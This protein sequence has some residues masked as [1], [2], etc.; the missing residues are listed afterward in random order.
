M[1]SRYKCRPHCELANVC[2]V[3][4]A[5]YCPGQCA[6]ISAAHNPEGCIEASAILPSAGKPCMRI[7]SSQWCVLIVQVQHPAHC[8]RT[9]LGSAPGCLASHPVWPLLS[10]S[11]CLQPA[12]ASAYPLACSSRVTSGAAVSIMVRLRMAREQ[13]GRLSSIMPSSSD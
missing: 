4:I 10:V 12:G 7:P 9:T 8:R 13:Q 6:L 2:S 5:C 1:M 11:L 3:S